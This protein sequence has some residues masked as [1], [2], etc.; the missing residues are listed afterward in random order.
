[1][2]PGPAREIFSTVTC[3]ACGFQAAEQMPEDRCTIVY[4]CRGCGSVLRPRSGDCCVFCSYG[5]VKCP[6]EQARL[7]GGPGTAGDQIE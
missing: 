4:R 5:T 7:G 1:M 3:P 2:N 6:P